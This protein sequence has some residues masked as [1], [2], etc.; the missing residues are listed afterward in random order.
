[1]MSPVSPENWFAGLACIK[2]GIVSIPTAT[3]LTQRELMFRF[4]TCFPTVIIA[5]E[6][7]ACLI[8]KALEETTDSGPKLK[9]VLGQKRGWTSFDAIEDESLEAKSVRT[10]SND[11]IF[12]FFTSGTTGLPKRVGHTAISYPVGHLSTTVMIGIKPDDIHH[13]LSVPGWA[14]W[15]WSS[16]F[17]PFNVGATITGLNFLFW[18]GSNILMPFRVITLQRFVRRQAPGEHL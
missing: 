12:C 11:I 6:D 13:N 1:M 7:S 9:L 10:R 16:F 3:T 5:D 14:K 2:A 15:A 18:M 17:A 4:D 8:D